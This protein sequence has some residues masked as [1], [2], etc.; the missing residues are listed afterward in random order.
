MKE[1][2]ISGI[3]IFIA[4]V[5]LGLIGGRWMAAALMLVSLIGYYELTGALGVREQGSRISLP[6]VPGMIAT[7]VLYAGLML[8][9]KT[10]PARMW[11]LS[12]AAGPELGNA[13]MLTLCLI[14]L[15]FL[16]EM[17]LFV[18]RFPKDHHD[19]MLHAVAAFIYAPV[20]ISFIYRALFLPYGKIVYALI[21]FCSWIGDTCAY[22]AGRK[23]GKHKLAP[24]LSPKKTIEGAIGG[25][26]GSVILCLLAA[27]LIAAVYR[28]YYFWQFA[29][30]GFCGNLIGQIGDLAAS[31]IKRNEGLK[32]YGHL[33]PG[34]GGIMDR[35][36]SVIFTAP[37][38]YF[39]AAWLIG[40]LD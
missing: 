5:V 40:V 28:E 36:D 10:N 35:F 11:D 31:G 38:L 12:A 27:A 6:E 7:I 14:I 26:A 17:G 33:I 18:F 1:R 8:E 29:L 30:I 9:T 24:V 22:F 21:F 13:N 37:V 34:H 25:I 20:M 4:T 15:L 19:R 32:D 3:I 39:L 23:F 2:V 16:C